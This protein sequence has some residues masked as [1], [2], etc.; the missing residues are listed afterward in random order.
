MA[1][2]T[3]SQA[4]W[5]A[6]ELVIDR[7]AGGARTH[8]V[9]ATPHGDAAIQAA[10][11]RALAA[12]GFITVTADAAWPTDGGRRALRTHR[13]IQARRRTTTTPALPSEDPA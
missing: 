6:L 9:T 2:F 12:R 13:R 4:Q 3:V 10:T 8:V 5:A 1:D 7:A 11:A